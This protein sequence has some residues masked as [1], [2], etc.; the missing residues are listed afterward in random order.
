MRL[1]AFLLLPSLLFA[2]KRDK[3]VVELPRMQVT[4]PFAAVKVLDHRPDPQ[5]IGP[6]YSAFNGKESNLKLAVPLQDWFSSIVQPNGR[7][8]LVVRVTRMY[9]RALPAG[10]YITLRLE[11][12]VL[13]QGM[14]RALAILDTTQTADN[15]GASR[16]AFMRLSKVLEAT[17]PK[18]LRTSNSSAAPVPYQTAAA[19]FRADWQTLPVVQAGQIVTGFYKDI[20]ALRSN[21]PS[22][23]ESSYLPDEVPQIIQR[24]QMFLYASRDTIWLLQN[25]DRYPLQWQ[26]REVLV[27][28]LPMWV[29]TVRRSNFTIGVGF[30]GIGGGIPIGGKPQTEVGPPDPV[31]LDWTT[32]KC[33][34]IATLPWRP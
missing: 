23:P 28:A 18:L 8:T 24:E 33:Y 1:I 4:I 20:E 7:D 21:R 19:G 22:I 25:G 15:R 14:C 26:N 5:V 6:T 3:D 10:D 29:R 11:T 17:L 31:Y 27:G 30:G 2:Q 16:S 32:G 9:S 13:Q 34:P 12:F